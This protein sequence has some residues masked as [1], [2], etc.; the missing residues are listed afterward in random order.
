MI[1]PNCKKKMK[2]KLLDKQ[3]LYHCGNCGSSFFEQNGI[4]RITL[5]SASELSH[6]K[7]EDLYTPDQKKCPRDNTDMK[8]IDNEDSIPREVSLFQCPVCW[9]IFVYPQDLIVFKKAQKVKIQFFKLWGKPLPSVQNILVFGFITLVS[10]SLLGAMVTLQKQKADV[11]QA[12]GPAKGV[13]FEMMKNGLVVYFTTTLPYQSKIVMTDP[14][15]DISIV[16]TLSDTPVMIHILNIKDVDIQKGMTYH[17]ELR[18]ENGTL[19]TTDEQVM[20]IK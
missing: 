20:E 1:C 17:L 9:G 5:K 4:N 6:E 13:R 2:E 8:E 3:S 19:T 14:V 12:S 11:S 16:K 10:V 7:K 18:D 15:K